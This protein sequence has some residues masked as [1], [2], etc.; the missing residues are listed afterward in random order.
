MT[1]LEADEEERTR[2]QC[3]ASSS[4]LH[5]S[6]RMDCLASVIGEGHVMGPD[7]CI[8][9]GCCWQAAPEGI[10]WCYLPIP[11]ARDRA[12][13]HYL[14]LR[15]A[16]MAP[17]RAPHP[18]LALLAIFRNEATSLRE[19]L[20]HYLWQG[21]DIVLL[22][23]NGSTDGWQA[24][25]AEFGARV[26]VLPAPEAHAQELL[27]N[28]V[29]RPWLEARGVSLVLVADVDEFLWGDAALGGLKGVAARALLGGAASSAAPPGQLTCGFHHFGSSGFEAQP[30]SVHE[31]FTWR[32][33]GLSEERHGKSVVR[34]E[35][36]RRFAIHVHEVRGA[37]LPCPEGLLNFHYKAQS[38]AY[39]RTVKLNRPDPN[40]ADLDG[41]KG[42]E[43][44][45]QEVAIGSAVEDAR[46]REAVRA[47]EGHPSLNCSSPV[48]L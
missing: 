4:P 30:P 25:V 24:A 12:S 11:A 39:W 3:A 45:E 33:S 23:D 10:P 26:V 31:C 41:A 27:Y 36:L 42:W 46:L 37:T 48:Y 32:S 35:A 34:L 7:T 1:I 15:D 22:L 13:R 28:E 43:Q 17:S 19:W 8:A 18:E 16:R 5:H 40:S 6:A 20:Q 38:R 2:E 29:G 44:F 14:A 47:Q 9:S 21:V